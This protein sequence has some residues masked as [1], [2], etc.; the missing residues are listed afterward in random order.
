LGAGAGQLLLAELQPLG[1]R[2]V[3]DPPGLPG[4]Q[5]AAAPLG[6]ISLDREMG[7]NIENVQILKHLIP[8]TTTVHSEINLADSGDFCDFAIGPQYA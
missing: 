3:L 4:T 7:V 5:A 6:D 8:L 1:G 2:L